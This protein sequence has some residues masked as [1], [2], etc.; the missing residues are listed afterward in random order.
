MD[1]EL[2]K[3]LEELEELLKSNDNEEINKNMEDLK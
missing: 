2:K 1:E 3:L